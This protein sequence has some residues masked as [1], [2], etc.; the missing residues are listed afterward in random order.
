[1]YAEAK[2]TEAANKDERWLTP[3]ITSCHSD[4]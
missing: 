2:D 1:L 3:V 4:G